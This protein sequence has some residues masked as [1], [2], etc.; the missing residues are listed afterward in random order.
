[1]LKREALLEKPLCGAPSSFPWRGHRCTRSIRALLHRVG[2]RLRVFLAFVL[3]FCPPGVRSRMWFSVLI[4]DVPGKKRYS[5]SASNN[6]G[7]S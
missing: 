3:D 4:R 6:Q 7:R 5:Y 2:V 1:M